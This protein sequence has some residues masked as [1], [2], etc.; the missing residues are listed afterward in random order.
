MEDGGEGGKGIERS[1]ELVTIEIISER[2]PRE[3][4]ALRPVGEVVDGEHVGVAAGIE[5]RENIRADETGGSGEKDHGVAFREARIES[6]MFV[7]E[8]FATNSG[9]T[10][11]PPRAKTRSPP[12]TSATL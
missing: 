7:V 8:T 12:T 10:T 11:R 6:T 3:V 4:S 5:G 1:E 9:V 2:L